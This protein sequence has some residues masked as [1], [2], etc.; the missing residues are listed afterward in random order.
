MKIEKYAYL[1]LRQGNRL[2]GGREMFFFN[3]FFLMHEY[4]YFKN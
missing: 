1:H 2:G 4:I 3:Y